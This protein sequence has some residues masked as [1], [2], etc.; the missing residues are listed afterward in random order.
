M[1]RR[2]DIQ[3]WDDWWASTN[4]NTDTVWTADATTNTSWSSR[5]QTEKEADANIDANT[6]ANTDVI[7]PLFVY[8]EA[9]RTEKDADTYANTDAIMKKASSPRPLFV[10]R[11]AWR[12]EKAECSQTAKTVKA[13]QAENCSHAVKANRQ[14]GADIRLRTEPWLPAVYL[15]GDGRA[16]YFA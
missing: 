2:H 14:K 16:R 10:Y 3:A 1:E 12:T 4:A 8:R 7:R 6:Y 9:W 15:W 11:E 5:S 13:E